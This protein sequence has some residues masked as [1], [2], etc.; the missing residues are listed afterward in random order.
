MTVKK[1]YNPIIDKEIAKILPYLDEEKEAK[2]AE[3]KKLIPDLTEERFEWISMT[4]EQ[5][6]KISG[7]LLDFYIKIGGNLD[8]E[9]N[10]QSPFNSLYY[11]TEIPSHRRPSMR[12]IRRSGV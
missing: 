7:E 8:P 4:P 6:L 12:I 3:M 11:G 9:Y 5:R 1:I 2:F 10:P